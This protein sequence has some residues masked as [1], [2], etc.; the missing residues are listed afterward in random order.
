MATVPSVVGASTKSGHI[1]LEA[2]DVPGGIA[3]GDLLVAFS[4]ANSGGGYGAITTAAGWT[5]T[6]FFTT[7]TFHHTY[8]KFA[9]GSEGG[10]TF[11]NISQGSLASWTSCCIA[12][13]GVDSSTFAE[14]DLGPG[15]GTL[16][17]LTAGTVSFSSSLG[18]YQSSIDNLSVSPEARIIVL[19][20]GNTS[21]YNAFPATYGNP[22]ANNPGNP[23]SG[24]VVN[25]EGTG[26][27]WQLF[28]LGDTYV[29][30]NFTIGV[31]AGGITGQGS[32]CF[33]DLYGPAAGGSGWGVLI[34]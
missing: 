13:R 4:N 16:A 10:S 18:N 32:H 21:D 14:S 8:Y 11:T 26:Y 19:A 24:T 25:E 29:P 12:I 20:A 1:S 9:S 2:W 3:A 31:D 15:N 23:E 5:M 33:M 17:G 7:T 28:S 34:A 22:L 30:L 27:S 6:N